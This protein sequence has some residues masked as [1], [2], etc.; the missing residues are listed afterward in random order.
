M[1]NNKNIAVLLLSVF[2]LSTFSPAPRTVNAQNEG[3]TATEL[4]SSKKI[5][6]DGE[7]DSVWD[8]STGI[9][10]DKVRKQNLF[11]GSKSNPNPA[12]G[13]INVMFN[14]SK[15]YLYAEI[16]DSTTNINNIAAWD[17]FGLNAYNSYKF[18]ADHLDIYLDIKHDD[19]T[20][21][22]QAWGS[23]YNNGKDVAAHFELAAG[24]GELTYSAD[25][26]SGWLYEPYS[27]GQFSLSSYAVNNSKM[28]SKVTETGYTFEVEIDLSNAGVSDFLVGK[29]IGM[30]V[31][32]FDRYE[33][34]GDNWGEQSVTT[35]NFQY[36][37][38]E[39]Q[40]GPGWLPEYTFVA[41]PKLLNAT[42][43]DVALGAA[44]GEKDAA[45]D[46]ATAITIDHVAWVNENATPATGTMYLLWDTSYLY[47]FVDV[48]DD[49]FYGYQAGTWLE[50]RDALE[51]IV[52]LYHNTDYTGG[53]GGDYRGDKMCEGYYKIAAGVGQ[54]NVDS[55]IQGAHW[56]WDDQKH[57]GS[58][59]SKQTETGYTVEYK[60]ALGKDSNEYMVSGREIGLG[61]KLYD[62]HA[63]DKNGSITVLEP[64]NDAQHEKPANLSTIKLVEPEVVVNPVTEVET[65][66]SLAFDYSYSVDENGNYTHHNYDNV[67]IGFG[68]NVDASLFTE[69]PVSAGVYMIPTAKANGTIASMV[70]NGTFNGKTL[71][72]DSSLTTSIVDE[73]EVYA[74]GGTLTVIK[75]NSTLND[76]VKEILKTEV[77]AA[78]YFELNDGTIVVLQ[79]KTYSVKSMTESYLGL[80]NLTETQIEAVKALNNYI[81]L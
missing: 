61:V 75:D 22:G 36:D 29:T 23:A 28:Y 11:D 60:I 10:I 53:Y 41:A 33:T 73:K 17:A 76:D 14:E 77:T 63:D 50:H 42:R 55:T 26:T 48:V 5:V 69:A 40:Y 44:D 27:D 46:A 45:Y 16:N 74:V 59:Y 32:Y 20:N 58:Y 9:A 15:L 19:P 4:Y 65:M 37:N 81:N 21:Y 68:A 70:E 78:V 39:P 52:D 7:K 18:N 30:Y 62:K 38:Y 43:T 57:N 6:V 34:S 79:D 24:K 56:M 72:V 1:K 54:A 49:T 51:M 66:A 31:G 80:D 8:V 71:S 64:K 67:I 12:T 13:T 47:V 2:A 3:F 25:G 35:T